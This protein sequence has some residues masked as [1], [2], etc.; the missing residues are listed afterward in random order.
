[1]ACIEHDQI[2]K[3]A[4][5]KGSPDPEIVIHLDLS[6]VCSVSLFNILK[7]GRSADLIGIH[8]KYARTAFILR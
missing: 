1:M 8:S 7:V 5:G 3:R 2:E 6:A 4:D